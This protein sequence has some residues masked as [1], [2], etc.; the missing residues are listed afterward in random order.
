M[1]TPA[2][3]LCASFSVFVPFLAA[4]ATGQ[5]AA[6]DPVVARILELGRGDN[7]VMEWA[8][9]ATNRFGGRLTGSDAYANA[10]RW[11]VWQFGRWGIHAELDLVGELPVGFN[12]GP[13]SGRMI[14]PNARPLYFGTPSFTAGTKGVQRG[15]VARL[16]A[17]PFSIP[18]RNPSAE[19]LAKK[20]AAVAAAV[21][22]VQA[23]PAAFAGAWVLIGGE[24]IGF[25]RDGRRG[26]P[27]YPDS[28][29][30]P[31]L[32][33]ALVAAGAL[34]TIQRSADP[35][36]ILDGH[37]ESW[38]RLPVLPD[39]KLVDRDYDEI[40]TLLAAGTKVELEF[41]IRNWFKPG[42]VPY[43][44]VV[45]VIPGTV[46]RDEWVVLGAHFDSFDGGT[47]AVDNG[48]GFSPA[49][50]AMRLIRLAG[51]APRRTIALILFAAEENGL[52]GSL[53]W[54]QNHPERHQGITVMINRDGS[55]GAITGVTVPQAWHA[56][57]QRITAPLLQLE[58]RWP[59]AL[60][61][62]EYP[63][64]RPTQIGGTDSVSFAK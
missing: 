47:G 2:R 45:A 33:N 46:Q 37:V 6:A 56:P 62:N 22:E 13:W 53:A 26:T 34:G 25:A 20:R 31:P 39:I 27:E 8:D 44:N 16:L 58:P 64:P 9:V 23:D 35:I 32:T 30:M 36:S 24:S 12:R 10:T 59:F 42:P 29:L 28:A 57:F 11:A 15:R 19:D 54:L 41:E 18:G 63:E 50:E 7:R 4:A 49:M 21:T 52:V 5:E 48:S 40:K 43:H 17:D 1:R 61:A 55:P 14:A 3:W 60:T 51:G 38:E